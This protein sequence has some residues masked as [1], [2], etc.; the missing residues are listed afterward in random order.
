MKMP[1]K[2]GRNWLLSNASSDFCHEASK[3]GPKSTMA[4]VAW[5]NDG[6][7]ERHVR[8]EILITL[9]V[10]DIS[11]RRWIVGFACVVNS[12]HYVRV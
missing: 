4:L 9:D 11:W 8:A 5:K 12:P 1:R 7:L 2:V 3:E 10:S 6:C